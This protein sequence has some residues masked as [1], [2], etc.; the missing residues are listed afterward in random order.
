MFREGGV[1]MDNLA[2]Y[3][4]VRKVPQ[5]AQKPIKGGR[6]KGMTDINPM[7][8]I[9]TITEQFGPVGQGWY[10]EIIE[11]RI[12]EGGNNEKVA[13]VD[14]NLFV[15]FGDEWSKPI[16]GTGGS[17]FVAKEK[18][19]F[20]TSDECFKMAL[21]DAISVACKALGV[22]ADVYFEKDRSKYDVNKQPQTSPPEKNTTP[23]KTTKATTQKTDQATPAQ[24]KKLYAMANEKNIPGKEMKGLIKIYY[25]KDSSKELTKQEASDLI[26]RI[27]ELPLAE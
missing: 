22:G 15:K 23:A 8:R 21:T 9:K 16:V 7:W 17:S 4:K 25:N 11:K 20:F 10:Y 24:L 6:L 18:S 2:I 1:K 19:G 27:G 12:E 26:E 3:N 5:E 14:I 13:F